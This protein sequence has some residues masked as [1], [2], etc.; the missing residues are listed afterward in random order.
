MAAYVLNR[1]EIKDL[2]M[3]GLG[4][5]R[6]IYFKVIEYYRDP[7]ITED[8]DTYDMGLGL[9]Y[10]IRLEDTPQGLKVTKAM[11]SG[12]VASQYFPEFMAHPLSFRDYPM[13]SFE[14]DIEKILAD[15]KA[16]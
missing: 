9:E 8:V 3:S 11:S 16:A 13:E 10:R 4:N 6:D 14:A 7:G 1:I 15:E 12:N 2:G 5:E